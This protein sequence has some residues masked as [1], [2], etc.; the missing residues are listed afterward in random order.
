MNSLEFCKETIE[1]K[2]FLEVGWIELCKRLKEIRDGELYAGRWDNFEDFLKDPAMDMDK[3]TASKM[4][5]IHERLITE[6][7]IAPEKIAEVGG[8]SKVAELLPVITDKASAEEW[9]SNA[10]TLSKA[11]L[12]KSV[13]EAGGKAGSIACKHENSYEIVMKCCRNCDYKEVIKTNE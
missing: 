13:K 10:A 1:K 12:R 11:D 7:A 9:L 2:H 5:T 8:W 6:Y 4:I 3:G